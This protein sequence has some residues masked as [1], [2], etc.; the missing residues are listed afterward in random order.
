MFHRGSIISVGEAHPLVHVLL[1]RA[2][3]VTKALGIH[4]EG[5]DT[6][7]GQQAERFA[8]GT[9]RRLGGKT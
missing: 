4:D 2:L 8:A 3:R 7:Q 5:K 6:M 1:K 9:E